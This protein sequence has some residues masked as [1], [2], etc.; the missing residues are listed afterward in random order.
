MEVLLGAIDKDAEDFMFKWNKF[1]AL[2]GGLPKKEDVEPLK[3]SGMPP[4]NTLVQQPCSGIVNLKFEECQLSSKS[5]HVF[6][7]WMLK[8]NLIETLEIVKI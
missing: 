6:K 7:E 3:L 4:L 2:K 1:V 8:K 5:I